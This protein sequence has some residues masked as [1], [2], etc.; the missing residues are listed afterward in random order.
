[1]LYDSAFTV[2]KLRGLLNI[3]HKDYYVNRQYYG[4]NL[5]K[6]SLRA[7]HN[8]V[9]DGETLLPMLRRSINCILKIS[10]T[11]SMKSMIR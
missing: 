11:I 6:D 3:A 8:I 10:I 4:Y 7:K 1:M 9:V 5:N 2:N